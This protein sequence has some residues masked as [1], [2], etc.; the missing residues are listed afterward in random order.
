MFTFAEETDMLSE[1]LMLALEAANN[2]TS[3][4]RSSDIYWL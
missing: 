4:Y 2:I 3:A 1:V